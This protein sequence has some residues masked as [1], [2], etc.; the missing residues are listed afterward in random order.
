MQQGSRGGSWKSPSSPGVCPWGNMQAGSPKWQRVP[1]DVP[2]SS[3]TALFPLFFVFWEG[4]S[5]PKHTIW[6]FGAFYPTA[7]PS[8]QQREQP[9]LGQA[10]SSR[11][12]WQPQNLTQP[13]SRLQGGPGGIRG[14]KRDGNGGQKHGGDPK[15]GQQQGTEPRALGRVAEP[16]W[17][18]GSAT[19][20]LRDRNPP[21][22]FVFF[23]CPL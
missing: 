5:P 8:G 17:E 23:S 20:Q 21:L 11:S 13:K 18:R 10:A 22:F 9:L 16:C 3:P 15:E 12:C 6:G 1:Q 7:F 14:A 19:R 4:F 2:R